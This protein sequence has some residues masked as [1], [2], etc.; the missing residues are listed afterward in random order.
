MLPEWEEFR[1]CHAHSSNVVLQV[2]YI[3]KAIRSKESSLLLTKYKYCILIFCIWLCYMILYLFLVV[4]C[5]LLI[6][7]D[8]FMLVCF[9]LVYLFVFVFGLVVG[10]CGGWGVGGGGCILL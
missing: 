1:L 6:I 5:F 7:N 9:F 10:V 3:L 4:L 8:F 2:E